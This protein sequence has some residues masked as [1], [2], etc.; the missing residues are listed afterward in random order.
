MQSAGFLIDHCVLI[1]MALYPLEAMH[2]DG[3][4]TP[5]TGPPK[6]RKVQPNCFEI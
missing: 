5:K 4:S 3:R 2:S 1:E 6:A